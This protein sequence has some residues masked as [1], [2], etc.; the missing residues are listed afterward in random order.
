MLDQRHNFF[1]QYPELSIREL[2]LKI[3]I[4]DAAKYFTIAH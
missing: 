4:L 2:L 1:F 3:F